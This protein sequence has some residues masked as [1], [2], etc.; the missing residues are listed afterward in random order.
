ML[1]QVCFESEPWLRL[2]SIRRGDL[3]ITQLI[4]ALK[5]GTPAPNYQ[6]ISGEQKRIGFMQ[7]RKEQPWRCNYWEMFSQIQYP[8]S[9]VA[10]I[11]TDVKFLQNIQMMS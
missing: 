6:Y 3:F 1:Y 7:K 2:S 9:V 11:V 4:Q 5:E 10:A 8:R